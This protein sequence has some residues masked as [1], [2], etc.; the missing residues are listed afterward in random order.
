MCAL[1]P[2]LA[3]VTT[4]AAVRWTLCREAEK[5]LADFAVNEWTGQNMGV[6][7]HGGGWSASQPE[8][9]GQGHG[10]KFLEQVL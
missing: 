1:A 7:Q 4:S 2:L 10:E 3:D 5:H 8:D 9:C 6:A